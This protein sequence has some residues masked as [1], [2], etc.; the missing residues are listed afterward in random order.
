MIHVE[1]F[2]SRLDALMQAQAARDHTRRLKFHMKTHRKLRR[3]IKTWVGPTLARRHLY[4]NVR[5]ECRFNQRKEEKLQQQPPMHRDTIKLNV[6]AN[7]YR[8]LT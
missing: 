4:Q 6:H 7:C 1:F 5:G 2:Y 3:I 8:S